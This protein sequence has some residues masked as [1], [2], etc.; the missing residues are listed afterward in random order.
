MATLSSSAVIAAEKQPA[1]D[2]EFLD[3]L[4]KYEGKDDNWTLVAEREVREQARDL[5]KK[6]P[7]ATKAS[8]RESTP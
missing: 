2:A 6:K 5:E 1:L 3:Y 7:R 4:L 8:P